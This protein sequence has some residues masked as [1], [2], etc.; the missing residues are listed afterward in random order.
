MKH[1]LVLGASGTVGSKI[2]KQLSCEEDIKV[3]GTYY[4][5]IPEDISSMVCF[6]VESPNDIL[7][8]LEQVQPDI[9]ISS[10]RGDFEKQLAVH[11]NIAEYLV[12]NNGKMIFLST[13]NVFDG[14]C[15]QPHYETDMRISDSE[16][17]RF[18]IRCED[19]LRDHMG[20]RAV[21]LRLPFVW[22]IDSPRLQAVRAGCEKG[23][24]E[25]YTK[26]FSNHTSDMQIVQTIQWIIKED[27]EGIFHVGTS[28][29]I[30]YQDFI[31]RLIAAT[32]MKKP[33]FVLQKHPGVMAALSKRNDIPDQLKWNSDRLILY[34]CDERSDFGFQWA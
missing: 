21:V 16:Y 12:A 15:D 1:V 19:L 22:G 2:F 11:R 18:K 30:N 31:E 9:V 34:L 20:D 4:S 28:D 6:S 26:F 24:L 7:S 14:S 13:A 5:T 10:L 33:A 3:T 29:V 27:K 25:V 17:G 32:D 8:V 23:I